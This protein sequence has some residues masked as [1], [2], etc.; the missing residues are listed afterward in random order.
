MEVNN[1]KN[2]FESQSLKTRLRALGFDGC[3]TSSG[4]SGVEIMEMDL[5][6]KY[7]HIVFTFE[8]PVVFVVQF[9]I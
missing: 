5:F 6:Y 8:F 4:V 3:I 1:Y 9:L 2:D 7:F